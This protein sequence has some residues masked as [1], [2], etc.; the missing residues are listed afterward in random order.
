[1]KK[2][3]ALL[4]L[5]G[6]TMLFAAEYVNGTYRGNFGD[7]GEPQVTVEFTLKDDVVTSAKYRHLFYKKTDYLKDPA[8]ANVKA[9]HEALLK[10]MIGKNIKDGM[11]DLYNPGNIEM[12]GASIRATKVRAAFQDGLNLGAYSLEKK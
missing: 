2:L 3:A 6:S 9:Q 4:L 7:S 8:Q 10:H 5:A 12:A 1:M 11:K